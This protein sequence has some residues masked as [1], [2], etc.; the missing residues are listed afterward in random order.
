MLPTNN[1]NNN[2]QINNNKNTEVDSVQ[3]VQMNIY[4]SNALNHTYIA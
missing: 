4:Q 1:V 3:S 2:K